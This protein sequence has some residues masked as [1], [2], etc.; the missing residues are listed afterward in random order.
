[1]GY[2]DLIAPAFERYAQRDARSL[3]QDMNVL[4]V[5]Q[6]SDLEEALQLLD[7]L[8]ADI[9]RRPES[10]R[11]YLGT[12]HPPRGAP[13]VRIEP[14]LFRRRAQSLLRMLRAAVERAQTHDWRLVYGNGVSYRHL[15]GIRLPPGV[16]EYS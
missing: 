13:T 5:L 15:V 9:S 8:D 12:R 7:G 10:W 3:L 6:D 1:M 16:V 4:L 14:L 11:S 2:F